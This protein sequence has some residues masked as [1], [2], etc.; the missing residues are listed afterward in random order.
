MPL[1]QTIKL[2]WKNIQNNK[3][4]SVLTMIG[5]IIGIS[6]VIILVS[7]VSGSARGITSQIRS[8]GPNLITV[9]LYGGWQK[10]LTMDAVKDIR[11][12][13]GV[14]EAAPLIM[15]DVNLKKDRYTEKGVVSG[16][17]SNFLRIRGMNLSSGRFISDLDEEN[18]QSVAVL[19]ADK[20]RQFFG[21]ADPVGNTIT[22]NGSTYQVVGVLQAQGSSL[23]NNIDEMII[24]PLSKAIS[25]AGSTEIK[26]LYIKAHSEN[27]VN[28]A[29]YQI[30]RYLA[31]YYKTDVKVYSVMSQKQLLEILSSV[32]GILTMMLGGI[33]AISLIVGGIGVMNV[34]LVSVS[35]RTKE[36][37]IRKALGGKNGDILIQFLIEAVVISSIGGTFGV[38]FGIAGGEALAR[39]GIPMAYSWN[40][41]TISFSFSLAVGIV[42]GVFPA[43]KA[44]RLKPID[45]LRYE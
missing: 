5:I 25:L 9:N 1:Y 21:F 30:D 41:I 18:R 23:G 40:I 3:L 33:A 31:D 43:Y 42:F 45:A 10:K 4:R 22:L 19:G 2:A 26:M 17:T 32:T 16:T 29:V 11:K 28:L 27:A 14:A 6:S 24:V 35:E 20:A 12:L 34:M 38:L 8:L 7:L 37:G 39:F 36:I 15:A 44:S 13:S